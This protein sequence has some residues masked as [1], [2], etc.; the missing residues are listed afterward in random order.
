MPFRGILFNGSD[1]DIAIDEQEEPEYF[2]DL[3]L[4]QVVASITAG[5]DEYR[6]APYFYAALHDVETVEYRHEVFRDLEDQAL[7]AQIGSF[8]RKMRAMRERLAQAE[9]LHYRYQ[10][11]R[12][13]L[14]AVDVYADAVTGLANDLA[15]ADLRSRGFRGLREYLAAYVR[16]ETFTALCAETQALKDGLSAVRY[17]LRIK[18]NRVIVTAY[19]SDADFSQEVLH[20]FEKFKQAAPKEYRFDFPSWPDMNHVEAAILDLVARLYPELFSSLDRYSVGRQGFLDATIGRF[21]REVQFYAAYLEHIE[22]LRPAG[23]AFCQPDVD[24]RSKEVHAREVFDLALANQL[25]R[26]QTPLVSN[27]FY[28][29]DPERIIVVTGPNQ[30]GKTTFARTFGQIHHLASIGCP[31]PGREAKLFLFDRLFVHFEREEDLQNHR[32][33]LEDDLLRLHQV[34]ESA[35]SNSILIMNESLSS[36]TLSDALFL[37][38]QILERIIER[39]MLSVSVTFLDEMA[40]ISEATVSMVSSVDP[41]DPA[42]RTFKLSR[43]PADGL[44]YAVAIAEKYGLTFARVKERIGA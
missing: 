1:P 25:V 30:G 42:R 29:K 3:N 36:T 8:A 7:F 15:A 19:E 31:V 32:G 14:D 13:F 34:I 38:R 11:E 9:K 17:C 27:D 44:A 5:R 22:R 40:S 35:T 12:W 6:L 26:E 18:G 28:L 43:R 21:D 2:A 10:Q 41:A 23:L 20:T 39:D 16:S 33:K 24:D 4:D 37:G